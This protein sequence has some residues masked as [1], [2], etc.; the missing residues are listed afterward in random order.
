M[1]SV[2]HS[3]AFSRDMNTLGKYGLGSSI[4]KDVPIGE[5]VLQ[6]RGPGD[7][8][9]SPSLFFV[10]CELARTFLSLNHSFPN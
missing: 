10:C 8:V 4:G 7:L 6:R 3:D 9:G 2:R 5:A 1:G